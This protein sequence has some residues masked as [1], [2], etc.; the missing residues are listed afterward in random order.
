MVRTVS[1][2]SELIQ[3]NLVRRRVLVVGAGSVGLDVALRLAASGLQHIT[4]MDFDGVE[5]R[6]LDRLIGASRRDVALRRS[7]IHVAGQGSAA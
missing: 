7:K 3:A 1:A 5:E 2:W 4:I 6:N